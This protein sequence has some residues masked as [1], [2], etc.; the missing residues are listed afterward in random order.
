MKAKYTKLLAVC[1]SPEV[2]NAMEIACEF[3]GMPESQFGRVA[4]TEKLAREGYLE[5]PGAKLLREREA[6]SAPPQNG[7]D[8]AR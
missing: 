6:K 1:V 2:K 3:T 4:V 8:R 7:G 5:H